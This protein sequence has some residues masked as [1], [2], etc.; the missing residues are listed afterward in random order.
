[1]SFASR[2]RLALAAGATVACFA[3]QAAPAYPTAPITLVVPM[4]AGGGGDITARTLAEHMSKD[5]GQPIIVDNRPGAT[6]IIALSHVARQPS[7]GY[8][9]LMSSTTFQIH[10]NLLHKDLPFNSVKDF[11]PVS[12]IGEGV[13][14]FVVAADAPYNSMADYLNATTS[15]PEGLTF[16]SW[17]MQSAAHLMGEYLATLAPGKMVHVPYKGEVPMFN[18]LVGGNLD[19]GWAT[20]M[21]AQNMKVAGRVKVLGTSGTER[22][23]AMPEVPT[24]AEQN[25]S[26]LEMTGWL[27]MFAPAG[28]PP[29]IIERVSESVRKALKEPAVIERLEGMGTQIVGS[30]PEE[31]QR[32]FDADYQNWARIVQTAGIEKQ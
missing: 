11:T 17:G 14:A 24:F 32:S 15:K 30:T 2:T 26:N 1:M 21:T 16:G 28:T 18:D 12:L 8:T 22:N 31:F 25:L 29:E 4:T 5:L 27:G 9:L 20:Q 13:F 19:G 6:G 7:D 23:Q 3:A 10:N